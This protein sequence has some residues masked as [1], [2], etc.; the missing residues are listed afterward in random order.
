MISPHTWQISLFLKI[1]ASTSAMNIYDNNVPL[2]ALSSAD[3]SGILEWH[4]LEHRHQDNNVPKPVMPDF[5]SL[6]NYLL[7]LNT[8]NN[9]TYST[10]EVM[11][12]HEKLQIIFQNSL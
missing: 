10:L 2:Q 3:A 7:D 1:I 8:L 6:T 9:F 4:S 12:I 11:K 5:H